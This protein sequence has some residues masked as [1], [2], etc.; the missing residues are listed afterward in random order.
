MHNAGLIHNGRRRLGMSQ[1]ALAEK[2]GCSKSSII[3]WEKGGTPLEVYRARLEK[4]LGISL[5]KEEDDVAR[6]RRDAPRG[7]MQGAS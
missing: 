4:V 6:D 5:T 7:G 3:N 2:V 1:S